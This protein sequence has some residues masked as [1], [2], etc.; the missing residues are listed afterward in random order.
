M[1]ARLCARILSARIGCG[2]RARVAHCRLRRLAAKN[3]PKCLACGLKSRASALR[4]WGA[5]SFRLP[6]ARMQNPLGITVRLRAAFKN[7]VAR[8]VKGGAVEGRGPPGL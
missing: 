2:G 5:L 1:S 7:Q 4:R 6:P 3:L 8:G